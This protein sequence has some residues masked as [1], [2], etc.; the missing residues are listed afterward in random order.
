MA[1]KGQRAPGRSRAE[2]RAPSPAQTRKAAS[3][4]AAA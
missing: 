2:K 1:A 3:T 4:T